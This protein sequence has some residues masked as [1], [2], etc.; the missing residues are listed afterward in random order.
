MGVV[1]IALRHEWAELNAALAALVF[2]HPIRFLCP[3]RFPRQI[4]ENAK[5]NAKS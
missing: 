3:A 5:S 1:I 2:P 4:P